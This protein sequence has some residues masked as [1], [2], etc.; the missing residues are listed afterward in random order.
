MAEVTAGMSKSLGKDVGAIR[1]FRN[2]VKAGTPK[3]KSRNSFTPPTPV[4]PAPI[5]TS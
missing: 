4:K 1:F 5:K 3:M 2:T